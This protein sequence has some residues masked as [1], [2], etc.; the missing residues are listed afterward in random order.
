MKFTKPRCVLVYA[1][2][3]KEL[4]AADANRILN[5][6]VADRSLPQVLF[7]DHFIERRGGVAIFFVSSQA[8]RDALNNS[9]HLDGWEVQMNPLIFSYN[10]AAFD[11]QI[12]YTLESYRGLDWELLQKEARPA[13]GNL[14]EEAE[15]AEESKE[16]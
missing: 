6:F 13:Y 4:R 8:E 1:V 12:R 3:P 11:E 16:N 7:H 2:A 9:K 5:E 10:P 15:T 14:R